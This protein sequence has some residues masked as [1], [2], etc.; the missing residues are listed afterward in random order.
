MNS[1]TFSCVFDEVINHQNET[2]CPTSLVVCCSSFFRPHGVIVLAFQIYLLCCAIQSL[3][4]A[5]SPWDY[6]I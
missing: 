5:A 6:R 2:L 1:Q 4:S 3:F